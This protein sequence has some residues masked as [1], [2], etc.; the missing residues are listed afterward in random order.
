MF[1]VVNEDLTN[2]SEN[3]KKDIIAECNSWEE[4]LKCEASNYVFNTSI[5][6]LINGKWK[7][8]AVNGIKL[9]VIGKEVFNNV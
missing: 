8:I 5:E 7:L 3:N 2:L 9:E 1:R 6:Q 4:A